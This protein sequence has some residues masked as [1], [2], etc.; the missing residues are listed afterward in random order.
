MVIA[1]GPE[2]L[3]VRAAVASVVRERTPPVSASANVAAKPPLP[4][5]PKTASSPSVEPVAANPGSQ[6]AASHPAAVDAPLAP[7]RLEPEHVAPVVVVA[8]PVAPVPTAPMVAPA[9]A[10]V[11]GDLVLAAVSATTGGPAPAVVPAEAVQSAPAAPPMVPSGQRCRPQSP[12]R[13]PSRPHSP[14]RQDERESARR[15]QE[16]PQRRPSGGSWHAR[17]GGR[18]GWRG[19]HGRGRGGAFDAPVTMADLQRVVTTAMREER[20][21]QANQQFPHA[22]APPP[23]VPPVAAPPAVAPRPPA[24]SAPY[25]SLLPG[26]S[27]PQA[28]GTAQ[29]FQAFVGPLRAAEMY[30]HAGLSRGNSLDD[31][32]RE[33]CL[34]AADRL[35]ELLAPVLAAPARG[36]VAGVGQ[37]GT[38]VRGL[39]RF[40]RA[41]TAADVI[42]ASTAGAAPLAD[43][44]S[45]GS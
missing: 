18:A 22:P 32:S 3:P 30:G 4:P 17:R 23:V 41:G 39:R 5:A 7:V 44:A 10:S 9:P 25:P 29:P 43:G 38:A 35:A 12:D 37:L 40:S 2:L 14:Y 42:G 34:D 6:A 26:D 8:P 11:G 13:R 27:A 28:A 33:E 45:R 19:G 36:G 16:S 20:A 1:G 24:L 15:R 21:L 31:G